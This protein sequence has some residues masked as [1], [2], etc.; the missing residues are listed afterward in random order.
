MFIQHTSAATEIKVIGVEQP[1]AT[2]APPSAITPFTRFSIDY[3]GEP[4][5]LDEVEVSLIGIANSSAFEHVLLIGKKSLGISEIDEE[6]VVGSGM[7]NSEGKAR[8]KNNLGAIYDKVEFEIAASTINDLKNFAGQVA[9]FDVTGIKASWQNNGQSPL[10]SGLPIAG[11]A[12]TINNSLK[13]GQLSLKTIPDKNNILT[14]QITE[15]T[16]VEDVD[17]RKIVFKGDFDGVV[18][19]ETGGFYACHKSGIDL[20]ACNF[21]EYSPIRIPKNGSV[22][23][24][25]I[26][27]GYKTNLLLPATYDTVSQGRTYEYNLLAVSESNNVPTATT[28]SLINLIFPPTEGDLLVGQSYKE[29]SYETTL[30]QFEVKKDDI[31]KFF[32]FLVTAEKPVS[33]F[34][35]RGDRGGYKG[36]FREG[37]QWGVNREDHLLVSRVVDSYI[38]PEMEFHTFA[39]GIYTLV[40]KSNLSEAPS[41]MTVHYK[42]TKEKTSPVA[43]NGHSIY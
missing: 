24:A 16:G 33:F 29:S 19:N 13:V 41:N 42:I 9:S 23:F 31:G 36:D 18:L 14:L 4:Y 11:T 1:K 39:S 27:D 7:I 5:F 12:N 35:V 2:L 20:T 17:L 43:Q 8:I 3:P 21:F 26:K 15:K 34:V 37:D 6:R 22:T 28:T 30:L 25:G 10:I 32:H 40:F 38:N